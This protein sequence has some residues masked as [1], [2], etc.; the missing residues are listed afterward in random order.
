MGIEVHSCGPRSLRW[1][2]YFTKTDE[3]RNVKKEDK[4]S[5]SL[6]LDP[7]DSYADEAESMTG[8]EKLR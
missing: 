1:N 5:S 8:I 4:Q 7:F 6:S 2:D 3:E